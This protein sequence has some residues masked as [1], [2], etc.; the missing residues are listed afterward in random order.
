MCFFVDLD[1]LEQSIE[2]LI[3]TCLKTLAHLHYETE[4]QTIEEKV[5][6]SL[7]K[8]FAQHLRTVVDNNKLLLNNIDNNNNNNS[9]FVYL[10]YIFIF[11]HNYKLTIIITNC[12]FLFQVAISVQ[13]AAVV[14]AVR[15]CL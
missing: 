2:S 3:H 4:L 15:G 6:P 12:M 8:G 5:L 14:P 10:C 13:M 7:A 9:T 1:N 11:L